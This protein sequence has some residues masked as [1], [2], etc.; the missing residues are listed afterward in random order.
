MSSVLRLA[1]ATMLIPG[2]VWAGITV[3][4]AVER[5]SLWR[6]M[7]VEQYA[8]D[9]R[10]SLLR[11]DPLQPILLVVTLAGATVFALNAA[12]PGGALAWTGIALLAAILV[13]SVVLAEPINARFRRRPEGEVPA[14]AEALR[15]RWARLHLVRTGLTVA[16]LSCLVLATTYG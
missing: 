1:T 10:R 8:I 4:Y 5:T 11:V 3:C 16:A 14:H 13:G 7:P 6:R 12:G 15:R 2:A 9:F